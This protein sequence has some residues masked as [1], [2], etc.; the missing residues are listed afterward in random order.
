RLVSVSLRGGTLVCKFLLIFFLAKFLPP[1]EVGVFGL[2]AATIGYSFFV[3][4]FEFY[5]YSGREL[6]GLSRD[7]WLPV[8]RD[9]WVLFAVGYVFILPVLTF[10][11]GVYLSSWKYVGWFLLLLLFEHT[12]QELNRL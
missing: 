9:Q 12:A 1:E 6:L 3:V 11:F 7:G 5:T 2:V 8:I 10:I 4:G